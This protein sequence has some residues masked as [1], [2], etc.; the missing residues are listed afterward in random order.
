MSTEDDE[1]T[2][3]ERAE[4]GL[5]LGEGAVHG[6]LA[7]AAAGI[8]LAIILWLRRSNRRRNADAD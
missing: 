1:W 7:A 8:V 6:P 3:G 5:T 2:S 4:I